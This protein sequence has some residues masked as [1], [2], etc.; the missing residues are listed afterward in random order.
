MVIE[1]PPGQGFWHTA[2]KLNRPAVSFPKTSPQAATQPI[3]FSARVWCVCGLP[4]RLAFGGAPCLPKRIEADNQRPGEYLSRSH[5][6]GSYGEVARTLARRGSPPFAYEAKL[7]LE[8]T[9]RA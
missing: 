6:D 8:M 3:D 7:T 2:S 4:K 9:T 5:Y 1:V